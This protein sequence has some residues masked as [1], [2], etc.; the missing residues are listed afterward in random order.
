MSREILQEKPYNFVSKYF[1]PVLCQEENPKKW[2]DFQFNKIT[3]IIFSLKIF[4]LQHIGGDK[5][6]TPS[7]QKTEVG[8]PLSLRT[9]WSTE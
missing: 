6:F 8:K 5:N 9:V 4:F 1:K 2:M 7:T 3:T